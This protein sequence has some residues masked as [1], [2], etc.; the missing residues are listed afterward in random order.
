MAA[1]Y[2]LLGLVAASPAGA[3]E[4][5]PEAAQKAYDVHDYAF[6]RDIYSYLLEHTGSQK[7]RLYYGLGAASHKLREYPRAAEAFSKALESEDAQIQRRAHHGLG[8]TLYELGDKSLQT[9]P[10][11]SLKAW[12]DALDHLG[13]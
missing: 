9:E 12:M 5:T 1:F 3:V 2:A 7:D 4:Y 11:F 6:A 8:N 13:R 10:D